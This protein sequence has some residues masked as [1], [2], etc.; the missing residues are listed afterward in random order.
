MFALLV[1]ALAHAAVRVI[2]ERGL[3]TLPR[4]IE[5][6]QLLEQLLGAVPPLDRLN[7]GVQKALKEDRFRLLAIQAIT[8]SNEEDF[9]DLQH[10]QQTHVHQSIA[11]L[12]NAIST[13]DNPHSEARVWMMQL[14]VE[15]ASMAL[16]GLR[17]FVPRYFSKMRTIGE[18]YLATSTLIGVWLG[19]LVW[20]FS[21]LG[22][23]GQ[24]SDWI[25]TIG[26]VITISTSIGLIATLAVQ[27]YNM[28]T[29]WAGPITHWS[30][31]QLLIASAGFAFL[32]LLSTLLYTGYL[33]DWIAQ[34]TTRLLSRTYL[35]STQSVFITVV[36]PALV[37]LY[38][39]Y[40]AM[41]MLRTDYLYRNERIAGA[42][43]ASIF[44]VVFFIPLV[45]RIETAHA[46]PGLLSMPA[47]GAVILLS[48]A[49]LTLWRVRPLG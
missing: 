28:L 26:L 36:I 14:Y 37:G 34:L 4:S 33:N 31:K 9:L 32:I 30:R 18:A 5:D 17:W 42:I 20:G 47:V 46:S 41:R 1:R 39:L 21:N 7:A 19:F 15:R 43:T 22:S 24:Y 44:A 10:I 25:S 48:I 13:V 49:R 8:E 16:A 35:G 45:Q 12:H 3:G 38:A 6:Q 2:D 40:R 27:T 11:R 29:A 23:P